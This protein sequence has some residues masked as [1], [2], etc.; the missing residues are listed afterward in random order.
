M[1]NNNNGKRYRIRYCAVCA[2]GMITERILKF[3]T[4]RTRCKALLYEASD[5]ANLD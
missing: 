1:F 4:V 3:L 2:F 5:H